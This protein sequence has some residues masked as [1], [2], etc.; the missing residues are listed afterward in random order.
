M[1]QAVRH[2]PAESSTVVRFTC[3]NVLKMFGPGNPE[4]CYKV[5]KVWHGVGWWWGGGLD[6]GA[7]Q[8]SSKQHEYALVQLTE[9]IF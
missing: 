4:S 3:N 6:K 7:V 5:G 9:Y 2:Q 8:R 1:E